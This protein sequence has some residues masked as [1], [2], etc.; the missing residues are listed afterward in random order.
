[1][2]LKSDVDID[3]VQIPL[4]FSSS[5]SSLV[6]IHH[7]SSN[8]HFF[9]TMRIGIG[10]ASAVVR[11]FACRS[12]R[13]YTA[14]STRP[15]PLFLS[16]AATPSETPPPSNYEYTPPNPQRL[17]SLMPSHDPTN[18]RA[19]TL[20]EKCVRRLYLTNLFHPVK[21]GLDNMEDLHEALKHPMNHVSY[22]YIYTHK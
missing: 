20:Y 6:T 16:T 3:R 4:H 18:G 7:L 17:K 14:T 5:S 9:L 22:T 2:S 15:L 12:Q 10:I 13:C 11:G 8:S 1:M 21:M 19:Y